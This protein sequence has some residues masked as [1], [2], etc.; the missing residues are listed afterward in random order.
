MREHVINPDLVNYTSGKDH[1]VYDCDMPQKKGMLY[2]LMRHPLMRPYH[3]LAVMVIL[4][5]AIIYTQLAKNNS[6]L[7]HEISGPILLYLVLGNFGVGIFIRQQQ[8]INALF[9]LATSA[10][11]TWPLTVRWALGKV[12]HFG[13]IHVGSYISG[14]LWFGLFVATAIFN[15]V[16][17]LII[18]VEI[19]VLGVLHLL[20]LFFIMYVS[21]PKF[22]ELNHDTFEKV[23][24][25]GN[26]ISLL[27][28]WYQS[29]SLISVNENSLTILCVLAYLTFCVARPWL[30]LKKIAVN[31]LTP[32]SHVAISEFDYGITPFAGS[33]TDL[34]WNPLLEWHSFANIP[35]PLKSGFRLCISR[36]GDW[37][38]EYIDKKPKHIWVKGVPTAG[39]GNIELLFKKVVWVATGSGIGPCL[40][41]LIDKKVPSQLVWSTRNPR[42][43]YGSELVDEILSAQPNAQIWDTTKL[44]R[45]NL[46]DLALKAYRQSGAEAVIVISNKKLTFHVNYELEIR[47][48]PCFGAIWDS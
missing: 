22:R 1:S 44:G 45:P 5:N 38:G 23:A 48:I 14:V 29:L 10:P 47:G 41:H 7:N 19:K 33:S 40:P 15:Q 9:K 11:K 17:D 26:W 42:E 39:V 28:F 12:Y 3:R 37:T 30:K 36:A 20:I 34:S 4:A 6:L 16:N 35:S 18:P 27:L 32:S 8:V 13:G 31:T 2:R 25:F 21:L 24:R 43:T 46:V